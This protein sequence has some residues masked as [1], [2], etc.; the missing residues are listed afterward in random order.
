MAMIKASFTEHYPIELHYVKA[1]FGQGQYRQCIQ[2]C[3]D[4]IQLQPLHENV[5]EQPL[6]ATF[7]S[8]YL[9]LCHDQIA[10]VMH[11]HSVAKL[12]AFTAAEQFYLEAIGALPTAEHVQSLCTR[13]AA[14]RENDPFRDH[15]SQNSPAEPPD[16]L[17]RPPSFPASSLASS[18]PLSPPSLPKDRRSMLSP[19]SCQSDL[20]DLE[21]HASF[22]EIM[23]PSRMPPRQSSRISFLGRP[24]SSR[25]LPRD[26]SRMSLLEDTSAP[27]RLSR[28]ISRM[29]LL[30]PHPEPRRM[31][32]EASMTQGLLRP[33]RPG[34]PTRQPS[35]HSYSRTV[36][37][38]QPKLPKIAT[39]AKTAPH[40]GAVFENSPP[41]NWRT[42]PVSPVSPTNWRTSPVSPVSRADSPLHFSDASTTS[43][44]SPQTPVKNSPSRPASPTFSDIDGNDTNSFDE[45][46]CLR[47]LDH[48]RDLRLQLHFHVACVQQ[49]IAQLQAEQADRMGNRLAAPTD[50]H[51]SSPIQPASAPA[52]KPPGGI[53]QARSYWSFVPEDLKVTAKQIRIYEGRTRRWERKRF[54]PTR[55]RDLCE[56]ALAEL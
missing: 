42:S 30:G 48:T 24:D 35:S 33:I 55:Y 43:A 20:E 13:L 45:S 37:K 44:L 16:R 1:L 47:I 29:S 51:F 18:S 2:A 4:I 3:R 17:P 11:H 19:K 41:N 7:I 40:L 26:I 5:Q 34:S 46:K 54:D 56:K 14:I 9:G 22:S 52:A 53:Q 12:P 49:I 25:Q 15:S 36:A 8:F 10:R 31:Q 21:S 28:D 32:R 39:R 6:R 27:K 50:K 38:P 23:T